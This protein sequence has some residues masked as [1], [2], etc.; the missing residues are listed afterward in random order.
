MTT[1]T[2]RTPEEHSHTADSPYPDSG[3]SGGIEGNPERPPIDAGAVFELADAIDP[4]YR[5]LILLIG[6]GPG[7]RRGE[8]RLYRRRHVDLAH[9]RIRTE[10][11]EQDTG[12]GPAT[13]APSDAS[14]LWTTLPAFLVDELSRHLDRY[15]E[16]GPDGY[17]FTGPEGG[18]I[19]LVH[20]HKAFRQARDVVG[21]PD[22]RPHD[23]RRVRGDDPRPA[24]RDHRGDPGLAQSPRRHRR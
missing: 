22:L 6:F 3:E 15:A 12:G 1:V 21:L 2:P 11:P 16:L 5:A 8:F 9:A 20:W 24:G 17:V 23:V 7:V 13:S 18:P 4:R 19:A 10:V 14:V